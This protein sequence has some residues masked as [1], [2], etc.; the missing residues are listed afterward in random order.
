MSGA[1]TVG[2]AAGDDGR[3]SVPGNRLRELRFRW[4]LFGLPAESF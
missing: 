3:V 2:C 4:F 1:E